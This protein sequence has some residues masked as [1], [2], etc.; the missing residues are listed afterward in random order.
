MKSWA[1]AVGATIAG[2]SSISMAHPAELVVL[3]SQGNGPGVSA[4]AVAFSRASGHKVTVLNEV[5]KALAQR[6]DNGPA[7]LIA[8]NPPQM[9]ELVKK[10]RVVGISVTP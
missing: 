6:L 9:D 8:L 3:T 7:D 1:R 2:L 4:L 10:G 5:G